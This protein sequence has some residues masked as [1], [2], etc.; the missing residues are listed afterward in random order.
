MAYTLETA[1]IAPF[2]AIDQDYQFKLSVQIELF[3]AHA[4]AVTYEYY[5]SSPLEST[6]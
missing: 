5:S 2:D 4:D 3:K 6:R 1:K